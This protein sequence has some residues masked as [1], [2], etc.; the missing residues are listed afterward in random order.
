M[1]ARRH[2]QRPAHQLPRRPA[3][4]SAT[5]AMFMVSSYHRCSLRE[6]RAQILLHEAALHK[7]V[8]QPVVSQERADS[9]RGCRRKRFLR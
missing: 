5:L 4:W 6:Q 2:S 1:S 9:R 8:L 7:V 3:G